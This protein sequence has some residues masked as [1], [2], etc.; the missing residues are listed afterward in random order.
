LAQI[1]TEKEYSAYRLIT[2]S[3]Q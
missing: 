3:W 2:W 1:N